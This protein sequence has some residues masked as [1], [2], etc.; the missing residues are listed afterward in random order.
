MRVLT[1]DHDALKLS[2]AADAADGFKLRPDELRF[3]FIFY[4]FS[5]LEKSFQRAQAV[6][7]D[8]MKA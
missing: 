2:P 1:C 4:I 8:I 5:L 3:L 7:T 6:F